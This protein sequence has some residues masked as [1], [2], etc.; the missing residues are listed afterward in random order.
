MKAEEVVRKDF[1]VLF[2]ERELNALK[3]LTQEW[4]RG[5][6][7]R[8]ASSYVSVDPEEPTEAEKEAVASA[9]LNIGKG[10]TRDRV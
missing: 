2:T 10:P 5:D 7:S 3:A 8:K 9:I 6:T 1:N 4:V